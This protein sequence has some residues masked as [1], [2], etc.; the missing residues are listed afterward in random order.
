MSRKYD[1]LGVKNTV[2][3][4]VVGKSDLI[5]S[6]SQDD[7]PPMG[8]VVT[9]RI[10][11]LFYHDTEQTYDILYD[12]KILEQ[13]NKH[14]NALK[15]LP[16]GVVIPNVPRSRTYQAIVIDISDQR[17]YAFEDEMLVYTSPITS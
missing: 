12:K 11:E 14:Q 9:D 17:I 16:A 8:P 5:R 3:D 1:E 4:Y 6:L 2:L 15:Y 7:V 10:L 13:T